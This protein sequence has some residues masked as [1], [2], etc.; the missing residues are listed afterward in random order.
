MA[1]ETASDSSYPKETS[2]DLRRLD[3]VAQDERGGQHAP[4]VLR[5][6][7]SSRSASA[8]RRL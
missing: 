4:P 6:R 1:L 3:A 7:F 2:D 8:K 5:T